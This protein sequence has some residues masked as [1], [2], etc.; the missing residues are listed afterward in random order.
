M[1]RSK[2][3]VPA[4]TFSC[5]LASQAVVPTV[6]LASPL[7][8]HLAAQPSFGGIKMVKLSLANNTSAPIDVKVGDTPMTIAPG[9][10]VPV[11]APAG[12][13]IT[14]TTAVPTHAAG[15]VLGKISPEMS[16]ATIHV[17]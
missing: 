12:T 15:S 6:A 2:L 10:T 4:L 7:H 13:E 17:N 9:K 8:M 11:S 3:I 14:M 16:G 5:L 1:F